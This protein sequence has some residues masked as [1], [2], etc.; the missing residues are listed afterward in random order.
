MRAEHGN[1]WM[2]CPKVGLD[3]WQLEFPG[4]SKLPLWHQYIDG[5]TAPPSR[6][7]RHHHWLPPWGW[8]GDIVNESSS[9]ACSTSSS[10]PQWRAGTFKC[11]HLIEEHTITK[12][13]ELDGALLTRIL[14]T[15]PSLQELHLQCLSVTSC[16]EDDAPE[17]PVSKKALRL[18]S[19]ENVELIGNLRERL[20]SLIQLLRPISSLDALHVGSIWSECDDYR[21]DNTRDALSRL[22]LP[23]HLQ[24]RSLVL[25]HHTPT[26]LLFI[27]TL[28]S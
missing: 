4:L 11:W 15:L 8:S 9:G 14:A 24:V 25:K 23:T 21:L 1:I 22:D 5:L 17:V 28:I 20:S 3:H 18:L 16:N 26:T 19:I 7:C 12:N 10:L 6:P 27:N 13:V 2:Y